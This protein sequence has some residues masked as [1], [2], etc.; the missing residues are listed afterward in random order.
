MVPGKVKCHGA[1]KVKRRVFLICSSDE[2]INSLV[3]MTCHCGN[4]KKLLCQGGEES[5]RSGGKKSCP[6]SH[7]A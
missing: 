6:L 5:P 1:K 2:E 3:M 4:V 7:V